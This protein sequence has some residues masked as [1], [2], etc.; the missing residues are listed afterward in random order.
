MKK[1]LNKKSL[2]TN[3]LLAVIFFVVLS[4][5][6][7]MEASAYTSVTVFALGCIPKGNVTQFTLMAGLQKEIWI[8]QFRENF[9]P[10][11]DFIMDG[12]DWTQYVENN[13]INFAAAGGDP[14]VVKNRTRAQYPIPVQYLDDVP[15]EV[16][17]DTYSS[18]STIVHDAETVELVYPKMETVLN[19]HRKSIRTKYAN[20]GI[21]N[22]APDTE[23]THTVILEATGDDILTG[24]ACLIDDDFSRLRGIWNDLDYPEENRCVVLDAH[25]VE[26][27]SRNSAIL[28]AQQGY[29][30]AVGTIDAI[31]GKVHGFTIKTRKTNVLFMDNAGT[32]EKQAYG[33][34]ETANDLHAAVAYIRKHSFVYADGDLTLYDEF[35][36]D[37][38]GH[39]VNFLHRGMIMP[40]EQKTLAALVIPKS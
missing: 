30:N 5:M 37:Y 1:Q 14:D 39:K 3:V 22:I 7:G 36:A 12:I 2:L 15:L 9:Y 19:K 11:N 33:K 27:M 24:E 8:D 35:S 40:F 32:Y 21:Y 20:D 18:D 10:K 6:V 25:E 34:V 31:I 28:K 4:P 29:K 16:E 17:L 13:K 38:Q 26:K 23:T